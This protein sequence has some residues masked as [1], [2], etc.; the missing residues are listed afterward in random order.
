MRRLIAENDVMDL[1]LLGRPILA[2]YNLEM[3]TFLRDNGIQ[4]RRQDARPVVGGDADGDE[5]GHVSGC[6]EC[7]QNCVI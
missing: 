5:G 7:G 1:L 4:Q 3:G 2:D 6:F